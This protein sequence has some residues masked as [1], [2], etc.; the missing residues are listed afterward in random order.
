MDKDDYQ[1]KKMTQTTLFKPTLSPCV[2]SH[3]YSDAE[4][5]FLGGFPYKSD[6]LNGL[7]LSGTAE[8]TL[9]QFL[10]P[11]RINLKQ[12]YRS[13]F[14]KEKLSY[15]G[16]NTKRLREA[17]NSVDIEGYTDLLYEEINAVK[18]N[19]IVPLDDISL[20]SVFPHINGLHKPKGRKYWTYCYRGS[21]LPLR[22]DFTA[23][24]NRSIKVIPTLSPFLLEMDWTAR[25]YVALDFK[26]IKKHSIS[27][28]PIEEFGLCWAARSAQEFETFL[29]RSYAKRPERVSFDIETYA[30][31]PVCISFCFDGWESCTVPLMDYS[32]SKAELILIWRL[33]GKV[34]ADERI[35]KNNQNKIGRASC[36]ER[37]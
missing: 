36:R 30:S 1:S 13:V 6:L 34:L 23:R 14:I 35:E 9:N 22:A 8:S 5:F 16:T 4:I 26:R 28:Q 3:G 32:I 25:N 18:P 31:V 33:V 7:A 11:L 15:S 21:V 37:V 29:T 24:L 20:A 12:C 19:V 17:L 10:Y 2:S 27:T